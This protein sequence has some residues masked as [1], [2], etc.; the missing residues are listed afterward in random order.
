MTYLARILP[1]VARRPG[2][3]V[4]TVLVLLYGA[5][6]VDF[7]RGNGAIQQFSDTIA[8]FNGASSPLLS[9]KLWAGI[10]PP[11]ASLV[12]KAL[13]LSPSAIAVCQMLV[14]ISA[15]SFL[16]V[17]VL[18]ATRYILVG[19]VGALAILAYSMTDNIAIWHN[20]IL[21]ES[22][23]LSLMAALI[24]SWILYLQRQSL[25]S[26]CL[27]LLFGLAFAL[28]RDTNA[29]VVG[30]LGSMLIII[31]I[32]RYFAL[33]RSL[34]R[35]HFLVAIAYC[36]TFLASAGSHEAGERWVFP[37]YNVVSQRILPFPART[38]FFHDRGMPINSALLSRAG[39]WASSD[40]R[41]YYTD[42]EL[43]SFRSWTKAEGKRSY[44]AFL[45]SH[46]GYL[47]E[48]LKFMVHRLSWNPLGYAGAE[49]TPS[50]P[51]RLWRSWFV[52]EITSPLFL[53]VVAS[54]LLGALLI[55]PH[56]GKGNLS[57]VAFAI[58]VLAILHYL[59]AYHGDAME[60]PRHC[61]VPVVQVN[62]VYLL[63]PVA[64]MDRLVPGLQARVYARSRRNR[65]CPTK[66]CTPTE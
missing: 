13:S 12:Y 27:V 53:F 39:K 18:T 17:V 33:H 61:L 5:I 46:P 38:E 62:L 51:G 20:V 3:T 4:A 37:F 58:G 30:L 22:L 28:V 59:I 50:L 24:A 16:A 41:A 44:I 64:F 21:S 6:V 36:A 1:Q 43:Q 60:V 55:A 15:W 25:A 42:P 31:E 26:S 2:L 34:N 7:V 9:G 45:L 35:S 32:L 48:P 49:F 11:V 47:I 56:T 66:P 52:N 10:R 29:Y 54:F 14:S 57:L 65:E 63:A 19:T 23:C 40:G 8:Y